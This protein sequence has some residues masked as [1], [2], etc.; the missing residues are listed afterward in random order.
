M[1]TRIQG[2]ERTWVRQIYRVH[3]ELKEFI[4]RVLKDLIERKKNR[5][6][7]LSRDSKT[8]KG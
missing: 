6:N 2:G 7:V 5:N 1:T 8:G 4:E 3:S